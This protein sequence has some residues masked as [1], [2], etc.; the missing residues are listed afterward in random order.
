MTYSALLESEGIN[1]QFLAVLK[2]RRKAV[3]FTLFAGSVYS[4]A[5]TFGQVVSVEID[6]SALTE[7]FTTSL[8]AGE[9]FYDTDSEIL[10]V[11]TAT[12]QDPDLFFTVATYEIYVGTFDAHFNRVPT[13][14]STRQVYFEPIIT[15]SPQVVSSTSDSLF[16]FLP[17]HSSEIA[18]SNATHILE[19]HIYDSSFS[20]AE[21]RIYHWLDELET[22]NVKQVFKGVCGNPSYSDEIVS[23]KLFS[24]LDKFNDDYR[25]G[26][27]DASFYAQSDFPGLDPK[28]QGKPIRA[29]YGQADGFVPVNTDFTP[30]G[31]PVTTSDNRPWAVMNGEG[32]E[33]SVTATVAAS[34]ASTATRT[35][36]N[37]AQGFQVGD[38]VWL[39]RVVGTDEYKLV[40]VVNYASNYIEHSALT[41]GAMA[42]G[43]SVKRSY[44]SVVTIIQNSVAYTAL[45][46]RDYIE[47]TMAVGVIGF[48]FTTTLEANVGLPNTLSAN[49]R[50]HA[51]VYGK[52]NNV[53]LGGPAFG[54]DDAEIGGLTHP[55][56][57]LFDILKRRMGFTEAEI[58]TAS[59]TSAFAAYT[60]RVG[61]VIPELT[62]EAFPTYKAVLLKI[63]ETILLQFYQ[64]NDGK[65]KIFRLQPLVAYSKQIDD[66]ELAPRGTF[67]Y[68]FD[69]SD[70][71]SNVFVEYARREVA[72]E[73]SITGATVSTAS[74]SSDNA[75][76]LHKINKQKTFKSI[77]LRESDAQV[78]ADRLAIALGERRGSVGFATKPRFFDTV[79]SDVI[80]VSRTRLPGFE[81]DT[82][83]ERTRDLTVLEVR[84]G[85]SAV[86]IS[87]ED[88]KG[89]EDNAGDW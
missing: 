84:R 35:Y 56:V 46:G 55:V 72:A 1:R 47:T 11:R 69:Y 30:S 61:L 10:Y 85:L 4:L 76:F 48:T 9:F 24:D 33:N 29:V 39:D 7:A 19:R 54:T 16:G 51:R 65:W 34:P 38:S 83:T 81:Y 42:S 70:V 18:L 25:H 41:G 17:V 22:A 23:V 21:I 13:D 79:I 12:N 15:Q 52:K 50:V 5:F 60:D 75:R 6:G 26:G 82:E 44:V 3:G 31:Q 43:D 59:F 40:M 89:I 14:A 57:I 37:S 53:T 66:T 78:L 28:F 58:N 68:D 45:Y 62:T 27:T 8:T 73:T 64:D 63:I 2:P 71:L 77:H 36:L 49:D 80:R 88:Q 32:T 86:N 67:Q 74:A 20:D 87:L